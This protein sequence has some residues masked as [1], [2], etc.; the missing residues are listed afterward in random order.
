[1]PSLHAHSG[2]ARDANVKVTVA[3]VGFDGTSGANYVLLKDDSG[4][5]ELPITIGDSEA[6]AIMLAMHGVKTDRP[7]THDLLESILRRTGNRVDRVVI[8]KVRDEVYYASIY[9]DHNRYKIDSRPSDAIAIAVG[10]HAPIY[11]NERLF[12]SAPAL[13][14][15]RLSGTLPET[16]RAAGVTVEKL[17][18]ALAQC[19]GADETRGILVSDAGSAATAA[20][21]ERGD[22]ITDVD[23]HRIDRPEDFTRQVVA[24]RGA[25]PLILDIRRGATEHKIAL[26]AAAAV[27]SA[28]R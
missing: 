25:A 14:H 11:V 19:F 15:G 13:A 9:L 8:A 24:N 1:M 10:T 23:S 7:L 18:P 4:K 2:A 6:Q 17:T 5:R 21:I 26:P 27:P 22:V 16:A 20:G 3:D 12:Q 28:S